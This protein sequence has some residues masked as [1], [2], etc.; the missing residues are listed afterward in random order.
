MDFDPSKWTKEP[1]IPP[2][3][4]PYRRNDS[5]APGQG[6]TG[7]AGPMGPAGT[8]GKDLTMDRVETDLD[9]LKIE[10]SWLTIDS[11]DEFLRKVRKDSIFEVRLAPHVLGWCLQLRCPGLTIAVTTMVPEKPDNAFVILYDFAQE[12]TGCAPSNDQARSELESAVETLS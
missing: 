7:P 10:G 11:D 6:R 2:K 1:V 4:N 3:N 8:P 5:V 9:D 12:L